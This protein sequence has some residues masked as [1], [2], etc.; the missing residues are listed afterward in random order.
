MKISVKG[1]A[2]ASAILW[3]AAML[4]MALPNLLWGNYGQQVVL[5]MATI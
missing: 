1:L 3:G 5:L 2:L 4:A